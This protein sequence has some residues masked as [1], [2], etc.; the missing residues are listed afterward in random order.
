MRGWWDLTCTGRPPE[1]S[2]RARLERLAA[3][4]LLGF[5]CRVLAYDVSNNGECES[6]GVRYVPL[7]EL[8][9]DA[10]IITL[11]CPLT[12]ETNHMINAAR[13]A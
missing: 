2:A 8:F 13:W 4:I 9:R 1:S 12:P 3:R 10:D 5:G 11:H 7:K 6:M